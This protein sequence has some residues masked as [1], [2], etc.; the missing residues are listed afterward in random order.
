[1]LFERHAEPQ[2]AL[3]GGFMSW[4]TLATLDRLGIETDALGGH[5]VCEV[6]LFAGKRSVRARL[7]APGMGLSR[8][9][10]DTAMLARAGAAG[11]VIEYGVNVARAE[12]GGRLR[13]ADG[14]QMDCE[15]L[16]LATGKYELRGLKRDVPPKDDGWMGLR[17][18]LPATAGLRTAIGGAIEL[19]LFDRGYAGLVLQEGATAN[20]CMA[21]RR[22]RLAEAGGGPLDLLRQLA[23]EVPSLAARLNENDW[24]SH[25]DAIGLVP[26]GWR[27]TKG[28]DGIFR[29]GDQAAVIPS[30]AGEGIGIAIASGRSAAEAYLNHGAAAVID[31]Q[32]RFARQARRPVAI[33]SRLKALAEKPSKAKIAM[34]LARI[35]GVLRLLAGATR[36]A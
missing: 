20:L 32:E 1:M 24:P 14:A 7:P 19:H 12:T 15:A 18:R 27:E 23:D 8:R 26:Y 4:Q 16:F 30:L 31:W 28:A 25:A 9:A 33:A 10:L 17:Y 35:P 29:L 3:C 22:S 11:T 34:P 5:E 21:L 6:A 2:D 13:L 36:I